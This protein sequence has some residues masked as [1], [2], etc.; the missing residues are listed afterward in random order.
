MPDPIPQQT[1]SLPIDRLDAHPANSNVMPKA[2]LDKLAS[3]IQRT[4]F[5]PPIIA[6]PIG[7]RYQILDG[8]HRT[9]VLK[10]L[11]HES[12]NCVIWQA[13]DEQAL[14]LLATLNRMRGEDDPRKRAALLA[15]LRQSMDIRELAQRLPEDRQRVQK[16]LA[17]HAVPPSPKAPMPM[18]QMPVSLHFFLLPHERK[19]IEHKLREHGG[20]RESALLQL[21]GI[22]VEQ[23]N[24]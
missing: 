4:G 2:L 20:T 21:L 16:M 18:D 5:Y 12:V 1:M 19:A 3:E 8:H 13:D 23:I 10:Q 9:L 17:I 15:K 14:L 24:E 7:E 6:R 22:H 11:G